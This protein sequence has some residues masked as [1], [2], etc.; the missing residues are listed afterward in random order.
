MQ[1]RFDADQE[2]SPQIYRLIYRSHMTIEGEPQAVADEIQR[3]LKWSR[4]WNKRAGVSGA[5]LL[6]LRQFAQVLEGPPE[7]VKG[8]F[9]H[10][11]CDKRHQGV[12]L[13]EHGL[14][15]SR[16]FGAWSMAYVDGSNGA[17]DGLWDAELTHNAG[18]IVL[19]AVRSMLQHP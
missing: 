10:I 17:A 3:I 15:G 12:T 18:D 2:V 13:L 9:G 6:N 1:F 4:E 5:L 8:L 7:V 11:A 16:E 19:K 14:V